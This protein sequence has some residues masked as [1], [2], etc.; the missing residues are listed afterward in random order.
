MQNNTE[1]VMEIAFD[2]R[3]ICTESL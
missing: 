3:I 2:V 1:K